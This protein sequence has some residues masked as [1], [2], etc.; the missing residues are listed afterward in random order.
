MKITAKLSANTRHEKMY[1]LVPTVIVSRSWGVWAF[2]VTWLTA[3]LVVEL[4]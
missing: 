1:F 4:R 2:A 3:G